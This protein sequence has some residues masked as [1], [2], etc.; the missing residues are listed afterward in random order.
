MRKR[1]RSSE[2]SSSLVI[3]PAGSEHDEGVRSARGD[4]G[5]DGGRERCD[6]GDDVLFPEGLGLI[7]VEQCNQ[8]RFRCDE[9]GVGV[10]E[11]S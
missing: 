10:G 6:V 3:W 4:E 9:R 7:R 5:C 1:V 2:R 8:A 11:E